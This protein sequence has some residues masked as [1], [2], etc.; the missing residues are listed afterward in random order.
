MDDG[1]IRPERVKRD[2]LGPLA[3]RKPHKFWSTGE[4]HRVCEECR[5]MQERMGLSKIAE[6]PMHCDYDDDNRRVRKHEH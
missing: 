2:C 6:D 5:R 1:D 4:H 3:I